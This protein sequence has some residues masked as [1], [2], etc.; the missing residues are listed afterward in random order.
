MTPETVERLIKR[1]E[2][3]PETVQENV[4]LFK[5]N[6][7][8]IIEDYISDHDQQFFIELDANKPVKI[9]FQVWNEYIT[10]LDCY[11][12]DKII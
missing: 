9:I 12:Y 4:Q 1:P 8:R 7:L 3:L 6:M 2:D 5:G 11:D 10:K